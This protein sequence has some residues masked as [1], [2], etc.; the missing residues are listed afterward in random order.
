VAKY[1]V[2]VIEVMGHTDEQPISTRVSDLDKTLA[3]LGLARA[4][5]VVRLLVETGELNSPRILPFSGG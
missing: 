5:T 1:D 4:A 3:G 2:N